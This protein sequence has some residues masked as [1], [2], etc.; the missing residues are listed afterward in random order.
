MALF[1][2]RKPIVGEKGIRRSVQLNSCS[3]PVTF[4]DNHTASKEE[5]TFLV[6][7]SRSGRKLFVDVC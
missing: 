5:E 6:T 1:V 4:R 3:A 2:A 7:Q